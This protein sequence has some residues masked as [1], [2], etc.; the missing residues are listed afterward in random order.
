MCQITPERSSTLSRTS[1]GLVTRR[2]VSL[3]TVPGVPAGSVALTGAHATRPYRCYRSGSNIEQLVDE[4]N[5]AGDLGLAFEVITQRFSISG[6]PISSASSSAIAAKTKHC[7]CLQ[8]ACTT[9]LLLNQQ[10]RVFAIPRTPD[11]HPSPHPLTSA[12]NE[13]LP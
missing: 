4:F 11:Q 7:Q 1:P 13:W 6:S 12:W 2:P 10:E 8:I 5:C 3:R 9:E